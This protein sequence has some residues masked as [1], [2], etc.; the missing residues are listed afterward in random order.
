MSNLCSKIIDL[1][2]YKKDKLESEQLTDMEKLFKEYYANTDSQ[3]E[4]VRRVREFKDSG[5]NNNYREMRGV[6]V[7]YK[8]YSKQMFDNTKGCVVYYESE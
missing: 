2:Q 7:S 6:C 4:P 5:L 8:I 3:I 1:Q